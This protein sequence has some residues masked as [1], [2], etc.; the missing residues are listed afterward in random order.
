MNI[1]WLTPEVPFPPIGGRNGV[2]NRIVQLSGNND[3]YLF[4]IA[5]NAVEKGD[6]AEVQ[7]YCKEVHFFDRSEKKVWS[8]LKSMFMPYS[9]ASRFRKDIIEGILKIIEEKGVDII[10]VDFPNMARN[11]I[12]VK[13]RYPD[14]PI[15]INQHNVEFV[16]MRDMEK[17]RTIPLYKRIAYYLESLRLE[18]YERKIYKSGL[19]DGISFFSEDDCTF[20]ENNIDTANAKLQVIPLGANDYGKKPLELNNKTMLFVG[21]LDSIAITN[22]EAAL[23]FTKEILPLILRKVPDAK[24]ILAGANPSEEVLN[25]QNENIKVIPNFESLESIYNT[26]DIVVIPL[27]SGGG[28]KGKLLEA[29]AFR[30]HI[31]TTS[32]G[33][34]GTLFKKN[35]HLALAESAEDFADECIKILN[36]MDQ[37]KEREQ[38]A[39]QLFLSE[40]EWKSIGGKYFDFVKSIAFKN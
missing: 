18:R 23:W 10:I 32:H 35:E 40:Y 31:V 36:G 37:Y 12:P 17:I 24:L 4:S 21:R 8:Y 26:T 1:V 14:L 2:Y 3:I 38:R 15:T 13:K 25:L 28:V 20:F 33:I 29:V 39:Y 34:E 30:K 9:V 16:R 5:Y 19:F 11:I 27:L 6:T 7:K 22:V